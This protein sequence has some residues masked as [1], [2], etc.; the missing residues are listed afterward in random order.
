MIPANHCQV[1]YCTI[2]TC[3]G[4][5]FIPRGVTFRRL[6]SWPDL[7]YLCTSGWNMEVPLKHGSRAMV[8]WCWVGGIFGGGLG[9]Q[10]L[11]R[12]CDP[13]LQVMKLKNFSQK[14]PR[15]N[16]MQSY[17]MTRI[18]NKQHVL[19]IE[20]HGLKREFWVMKSNLHRPSSHWLGWGTESLCCGEP[21]MQI[22]L[23]METLEMGTKYLCCRYFVEIL[24]G[25]I[26]S[27][28]KQMPTWLW[29]FLLSPVAFCCI[30]QNV[31]YFFRPGN[32]SWWKISWSL[33]LQ[34]GPWSWGRIAENR[35]V[36]RCDENTVFGNTRNGSAHWVLRTARS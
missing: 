5:T 13:V 1:P 27:A 12:G 2:K 19:K 8:F 28:N 33:A 6:S 7:T 34:L 14:K 21:L 20:V 26:T 18:R 22:I 10:S 24:F 25:N 15:M 31:R 29:F 3:E 17:K 16:L 35:L 23:R 4:L 9:F 11:R 32:L 30:F 36:C